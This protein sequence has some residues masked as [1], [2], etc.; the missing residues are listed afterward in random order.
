MIFAPIAVFFDGL[1][2]I[3]VNYLDKVP[4]IWNLLFHM[5]FFISMDLVIYIAYLYM[6][7]NEN[8]KKVV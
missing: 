1:T 3:T 2:S 8:V 4:N 7:D 6:I 5:L